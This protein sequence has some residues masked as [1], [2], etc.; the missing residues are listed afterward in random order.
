[1]SALRFSWALIEQRKRNKPPVRNRLGSL[2]AAG[3]VFARSLCSVLMLDGGSAS[4]CSLER[5]AWSPTK[6]TKRSTLLF[7]QARVLLQCASNSQNAPL[8]NSQRLAQC[9]V[10]VCTRQ[11]GASRNPHSADGAVCGP[12]QRWALCN[13]ARCIALCGVALGAA[14]R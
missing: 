4:P 6:S 9:N 10:R 2:A 12:V 5:G 11:F 13:A 8:Y 3:L 1:M 7:A 14:L